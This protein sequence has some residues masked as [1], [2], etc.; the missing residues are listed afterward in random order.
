MQH[1]GVRERTTYEFVLPQSTGTRELVPSWDAQNGAAVGKRE[2][3]EKSFR[4][5]KLHSRSD[6]KEE[7]GG[8]F[9]SSAVAAVATSGFPQFGKLRGGR[10]SLL[11]FYIRKMVAAVSCHG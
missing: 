4:D 8:T 2:N 3:A 9:F 5:Q 1:K 7:E 6:G 11:L 10:T